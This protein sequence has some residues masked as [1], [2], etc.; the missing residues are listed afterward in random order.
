M[1]DFAS[2]LVL[3]SVV[4][5][6]CGVDVE[7]A[8]D[9][10]D[11]QITW[12]QEPGEI[13]DCH[14]FKLGNTS[15]IEV[16]R[17][18][19]Q[20][21]EGSHHVH[22]YRSNEP[23]ADKVYDCFKGIDWTK[24]S[25]VMGAQTKSMDWQLPEGVTLPL[26][27]HQ[28][29]LAQVHWLNTTDEPVSE[30]ID[31]SFHTTEY[32]Q[33]HLGTVFGVN[34]RINIAP[35]QKTKVQ[36]FCPVPEGAKVHAMMGH[37]HTHGT[38]YKVTERMADQLDGKQLY[39]S[40]DE[41]SFEFQTYAPAH[42]VA[43][44]AGFEY[45]CNFFNWESRTLTWGSDTQTQEHCNMTVYYSPAESVTSLCLNAPSKLAALTPSSETVRAG[46]NLTFAIELA[47]P[48]VTDVVVA[49]Q[50][51]DVQG[52]TVPASV[53][54]L[55]GQ[56]HASFVAQALRPGN[57]EVSASMSD[58]RVVTPI[59]VGGLVVS[60]VFYNPATG[61]QDELQWIELA[62][63]SD[64]ALDLSAYTLGAGST[65]F[66]RTRVAL[67]TTIPARGCIVVGGPVSAPANHYPTFT[68]ATDIEPNLGLG[69]TKAAGVGIFKAAGMSATTRPVDAVVY[70]G[71]NTTLRGPDG[72]LAPVWPGS[73]PGGSIK[74]MTDGVW[75]KS[76]APSPGVCEILYTN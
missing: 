62:N 65:D 76:N 43:R 19:I 41:P 24:W 1:R 74:R 60:E 4:S 57:F 36:A 27:P 39:Y 45:E 8:T 37:F 68:L 23:E 52:L 29:L 30:K 51:S 11:H 34:Q 28:Q 5:A 6:G 56:I 73:A 72:Q 32:S 22:L 15:N 64:V 42:Q 31:I 69:S 33:E 14:V 75:A 26:E 67:P 17:I 2:T 49:L 50:S 59:R 47:A 53:K 38:G 20:F 66:T 25:L 35:G 54:V 61:N 70:G 48:E 16:D 46:Q 58:A 10:H 21:P 63:Q 40:P 7:V 71:A 9:T 3:L 18:K 12:Q 13:Q 55:A 44:G